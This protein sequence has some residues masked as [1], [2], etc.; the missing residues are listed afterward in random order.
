MDVIHNPNALHPLD[1]MMLPGTAHHRVREDGSFESLVPNFQ[2]F[3]STTTMVDA[4]DELP[5][6]Q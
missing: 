2:L 5:D 3:S 6:E 4:V 1:S